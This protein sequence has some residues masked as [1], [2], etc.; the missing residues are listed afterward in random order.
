MEKYRKKLVSLIKKQ[1]D[2]DIDLA[3]PPDSTFGDYALACFPFA[4][5]LKK[6]P[7]GIAND[8]KEKIK[9]P[10]FVEK[11]ETKG[12]YLN[13]FLDKSVL[14]KEIIDSVLKEK[15][16][17][18]QQSLGSEK[19]MI[20]FS[21]ANTHKAFHIGHVRGTSLGESLARILSFV[22]KDVLRVNYQGDTGMHVA[23]WIWCYQKY[24]AK[25]KPK[26]DEAWIASIYVDA[27]KR[28][29]ENEELQ[30]EVDEINRLLDSGEDKKLLSLWKETRQ[31]SL[32]AFENIYQELN[33]SFDK[34][35]FES[36]VEKRGKEISLELVKKKIAEISEGATII[37]MKA[38]NL[39]V[40]VL[41]RSDGTVLYSAKDVA[42]AEQKFEKYKVDTSIYVVGKEQ[43]H[44]FSQLF[45]TLELMKFKQAKKCRYVPVSLVKLPWGKMSSRTGD[46]ILFSTFKEELVDYAAEEIKKRGEIDEKELKRRSDAIA[47][48]SLK[49]SMLRQDPNKVIVFDKTEAMRF[50]GETGPYLLY[51]YARARSILRKAGKFSHSISAPSEKEVAL[52]KTLDA[53]SERVSKAASDLDPSAIANY[54]FRLAQQFNEFYGACK[55]IGSEEQDFR[56]TLVEAFCIVLKNSLHLLGIETIEKM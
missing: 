35:F 50:E 42:L 36:K 29:A 7:V 17:Y 3:V 32:D 37:D 16:K 12:P 2:G 33:T 13:F 30:K 18:G 26:K 24:H 40:W 20:E 51:S 5:Q 9:A 14:A 21:Q 25:E 31:D 52:I 23:K 39:G 41:L 34:Y 45:K 6:D 44:H 49:Y 46:N 19:V 53:F 43:E 48:A 4:K 54:S 56:L 15:E 8:L 47:I 38:H 10:S 11:I 27:I 1:I 55:V 28:L 22:G